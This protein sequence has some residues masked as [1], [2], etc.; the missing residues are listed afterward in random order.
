MF[1][2]DETPSAEK[3]LR[4]LTEIRDQLSET[5][6]TILRTQYSR[7]GRTV[8]SQDVRDFL[9][10]GGIGASNL[11]YGHLGKKFGKRLGFSVND[12]PPNRPGWWRAIATSDKVGDHF[13][14]TLRPEFATAL[15]RGGIVD[16]ETDGMI[17]APDVD[18]PQS[19]VGFAVEGPKAPC[20]TPS[21]REKSCPRRSKEGIRQVFGVRGLWI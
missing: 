10:Y 9:E 13:T 8:S 21:S 4:V 6:L 19:F 11:A 16:T 14:W 20:P 3:F 18:L 12:R 7:P 1:P 15:E 5:D 17:D 2:N